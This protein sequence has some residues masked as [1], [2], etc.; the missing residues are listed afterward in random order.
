MK[1]GGFFFTIPS[2]L[3]YKKNETHFPRPIIKQYVMIV[4]DLI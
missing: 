3:I 1:L 2:N 4:F